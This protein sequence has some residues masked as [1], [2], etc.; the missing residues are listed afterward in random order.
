MQC[1]LESLDLKTT[2]GTDNVYWKK[3]QNPATYSLIRCSNE[4]DALHIPAE[5]AKNAAVYILS[6]QGA[7]PAES[8][9]REMAKVFGYSRAGDNVYTAMLQGIELACQQSLI[10]KSNNE[11]VALR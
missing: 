9:I 8:L 7:Q 1:I 5:E 3:D 11:R 2:T 6:Q 4:R 10:D